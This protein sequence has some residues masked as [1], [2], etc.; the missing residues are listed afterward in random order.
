MSS[1][2]LTGL[3]KAEV[4]RVKNFASR[5]VDRARRAY[6]RITGRLSAAMHSMGNNQ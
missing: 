4:E 2:D 1:A 5:Q 6:G 3:K